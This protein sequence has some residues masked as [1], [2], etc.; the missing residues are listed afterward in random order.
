MSSDSNAYYV[1]HGTRWPIL[2]SVG[3]F[4][5]VAGGALMMNQTSGGLLVL[6]AGLPPPPRRVPHPI[7]P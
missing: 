3:L 5:L 1:P 2:G 4:M 7:G 6:L